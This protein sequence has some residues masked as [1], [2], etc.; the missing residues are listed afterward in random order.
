MI[1]AGLFPPDEQP[2][3]EDGA[4]VDGA[5][6]ARH[7]F[8]TDD[9]DRMDELGLF[10][11][12]ERI[13]LLDGEI[14]LMARVNSPHSSAIT[15][16][17]RLLTHALW[18]RATV[19]VRNP[20]HLA[21]ESE[22]QPDITLAQFREDGY[23]VAHPTPAEMFLVVEVMDSSARF[24]RNKKRPIYARAGVPELWLVDVPGDLI[25]VHRR[26]EKGLYIEKQ[27]L[28]RGETLSP[29]AF[30]DVVLAVEAILGPMV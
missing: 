27:T 19:I 20:S 4:I 29:A 21:P 15:R 30:P 16:L 17:N 2:I 22:P 26:P 25:E 6:G 10:G 24:D 7:R 23:R 3:L 5:T 11:D 1:D 13:E 12:D 8:T 14:Y 28:R 18:D 9:L